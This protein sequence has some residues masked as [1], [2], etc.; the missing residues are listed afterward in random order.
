M[1]YILAYLGAFVAWI[2]V[3][4]VTA[5]KGWEDSNGFHYGEPERSSKG[6][7]EFLE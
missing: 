1:G 4:L 6:E 2:V 3:M 7:G 5:E